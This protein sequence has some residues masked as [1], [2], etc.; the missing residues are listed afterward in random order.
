MS[1]DTN[2]G[3]THI[4]WDPKRINWSTGAER[5]STNYVQEPQ[6]Q[7]GRRMVRLGS[8]TMPSAIDDLTITH[9]GRAESDVPVDEARI[10]LGFLKA[11]E[12]G[13]G[14]EMG[15]K[16]IAGVGVVVRRCG[17][18]LQVWCADEPAPEADPLPAPPG[19]YVHERDADKP[20]R[21]NLRPKSIEREEAEAAAEAEAKRRSVRRWTMVALASMI[22]ASGGAGLALLVLERVTVRSFAVAWAVVVIVAAFVA[23]VFL[24]PEKE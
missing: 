10:A 11:D 19:A 22:A 8:I 3:P 12:W 24:R 14:F 23:A 2:E 5:L 9:Y 13:D 20:V 7:R 6:R 15:G 18:R 17:W 4:E 21:L 16:K 1:D